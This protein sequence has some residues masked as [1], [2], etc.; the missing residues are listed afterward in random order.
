M[1]NHENGWV[2]DW[3]DYTQC[4]YY[5]NYSHIMSYSMTLVKKTRISV[6]YMCEQAINWLLSDE[7]S[8][9][10]RKIWIGIYD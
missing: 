8:D 3:N 5:V 4:K 7:V 6:V 2:A 9:E 10:E 1:I